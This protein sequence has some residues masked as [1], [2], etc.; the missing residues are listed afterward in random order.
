V[1]SSIEQASDEELSSELV[2]RSRVRQMEDHERKVRENN[3]KRDQWE[4]RGA[5]F[6]AGYGLTWAQ[7][8]EIQDFIREQ[9]E[10][11]DEGGF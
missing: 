7:Y 2:R 1:V 3:L 10:E 8:Q 9:D 6:A 11:R 4:A 5:E